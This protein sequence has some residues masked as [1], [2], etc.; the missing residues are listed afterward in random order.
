MARHNEEGAQLLPIDQED[1]IR[2]SD[3]SLS[4]ASTTSLVFER[5]GNRV[6]AAEEETAGI[7]GPGKK[8]VTPKFPPRGESRAYVDDEYAQSPLREEEKDYDDLETG[9]FLHNR[10]G[11]DKGVDK[12]L[13]RLIW[14]IGGIFIGVWL[15]TI[16]VFLFRQ[17]YRH[18]STTPHDPQATASRGNGK[19]IT[20]EQV[21]TGQWRARK[22]DISWIEGAN[23]EDGLLLETGQAGK[24]YL[25]VEDVRNDGG[26]ASVHASKTL[27]E[28]ASFRAGDRSLYPNR[29][30][31]SKDLKKVLVATDYQSNWRH[32]FVA[33]YWIFDVASQM[34][35]PL[36]PASPDGNIQLASWSPQSDAVVFVRDNNLFL[37]K[38]ASPT[39]TQITVDGGADLF[40]GIPDWVYEEEVFGGNSATWWAED[41][42]YLAFLRT[43]ES[44]VPEYPIQYFVS[45]PSGETPAP[46]EE[47]YPEVR[48]IKYPK[49]GAPNPT[50]DLL[51][52]DVAKGDVFEVTATDGFAPD[53]LLITEVIWAGSTG[54]ALIRETNRESDILRVV[55]V[56]VLTRTGKTV[57]KTN[58]QKLD[59]GWFEV[60]ENTKYIPADPANG[61]PEDGYIDTVIHDG[62]DHIGYFTPMS[63]PNP[64]MLTSGN[65]EVVN[66]PSAIDLKNNLVYFVATKESSLQRHVYSVKVDGTGMQ[67]LTDISSEGF[68]SVSFSS[69]AAYALLTYEGPNIPWQKVISTPSSKESYENIIEENSGLADMAKKHE[70]PLMI[71]STVNVDGYELNVV[72]RR[73]PHFNE[74]KKYPVL[75]Y[76]YG[77]PG[78]QSVDKTFGVTFQEY[79]AA[80]LGYIVVTVDGR[81]TGFTGRK[82]R[83]IIRGNLGYYEAKDQIATAK[84]WAQKKY[85]DASRLAIWGWSYGGFMTLKTL[86]QDAGQ[87]FSYGMAV[88]PVTDW[89]FYDSIYTERYMHTPQHNPEGYANSSISNVT[90]LQ[91]N[92]RFLI[93]HGV[94]DDNVHMQ[95]SL[96]LLDKLDVAGVENYDVHVFPDSD[97]GIYFHNA[98]KIVYDKLNNWLIN[99]FNGEWLRTSNAV[100]LQIDTAKTK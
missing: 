41:G 50:V 38:L 98:N 61:R 58:V 56:D 94:A 39:V 66:A 59:G 37:R 13:R 27:M 54:K 21:M 88:A 20:L 52:Y 91:Q 84:I 3:D 24:P 79:I 35:E 90:A 16:A 80:S 6:A 70:L 43:N 2:K 36:D 5:I 15:F 89:R 1:S 29:V 49:A 55:L 71:Y 73:P 99:A 19:K 48:Q 8:M 51:F 77:G 83:V 34:A 31:P 78:S 33:K 93:M 67:A 9:P 97:H 26:D 62:Y 65:W 68:H 60:S 87:T 57:R 86:E 96:T 76:L 95:N 85:V 100:P 12:K 69:G 46:G 44:A 45:R 63:N 75:F 64:V 40:Y 92:V 30:T 11:A 42:K 14:I 22:H 28:Q 7:H 17:T 47:N 32:S 25:V 82:S 4:S 72:E 81:G 74:K 18:A 10:D 23:G 53:D